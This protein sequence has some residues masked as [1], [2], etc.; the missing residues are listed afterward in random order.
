MNSICL[1]LKVQK[2]NVIRS[3]QIKRIRVYNRNL[4]DIYLKRY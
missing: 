1:Y 4:G 3:T 2:M